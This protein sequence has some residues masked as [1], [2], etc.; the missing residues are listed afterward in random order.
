MCKY[1]QEDMKKLT[2]AFSSE[3]TALLRENAKYIR[4]L[5]LKITKRLQLHFMY[6]YFTYLQG[7]H[8]GI[9]ELHVALPL[10]IEI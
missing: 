3:L 5:I 4:N 7:A 2:V 8:K 10:Q 1:K 6:L 9:A